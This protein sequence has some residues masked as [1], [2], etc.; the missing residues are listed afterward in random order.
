MNTLH[1]QFTYGLLVGWLLFFSL[2]PVRAQDDQPALDGY[3]SID[4]YGVVFVI[5]ANRFRALEI[6]GGDC[7]EIING[8]LDGNIVHDAPLLHADLVLTIEGEELVIWFEDDE[9][10]RAVR[11]EQLPAECSAQTAIDELLPPAAAVEVNTLAELDE[12]IAAW[13]EAAGVPGLAIALV[14]EEG[15]AWSRGYGFANL[16]TRRPVTPDTPFLISSNSKA[17]TVTALMRGWQ[18]GVLALDDDINHYLPF[19]VDNP[20][21]DGETITLRDL[22]T[23]TSS[24]LDSDYY[25]QSYQPGDPVFDL[26]TFLE[27]YLTPGGEWYDA[28]FN[29][30][31]AEPGTSWQYGNVGIALTAL[32][33]QEA[34]GQA[35]DDY[36]EQFLF[37]P[38]GMTN[39]HWFLADYADSSSLAVPY[40]NDYQPMD[41][42]GHPTW[43]AGQLR[44]SVRDMGRFLAAIMNGGA[45]GDVRILDAATVDTMLAPQFGDLGELYARQALGWVYDPALGNVVGHSGG[46]PGATVAMFFDPATSVG[47]VI[48]INEGTVKA[49]DLSTLLIEITIGRADEF[50]ALLA[51]SE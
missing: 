10:G 5:E 40:D 17:V 25:V 23:H 12:Q 27:G 49:I 2:V 22:M 19:T 7:V 31:P 51:V 15:V 13:V 50:P 42:F 37:E 32:I 16:A 30:A 1:K 33:L 14:N 20:L 29:F 8:P 38:L 11:L 45:L 46:D 41:H 47:I 3:W 9:M 24:I 36:C 26:V 48:L 35:F 21:L 4:G 44:S 18:D 39:T 28:E 34:T 6:S 43:P